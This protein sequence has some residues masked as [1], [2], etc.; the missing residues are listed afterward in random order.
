M[1]M[2]FLM[3]I[4]AKLLLKQNGGSSRE[5]AGGALELGMCEYTHS[6]TKYRAI[7]RACNRETH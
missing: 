5:G 7:Y 4:I 1:E 2:M 3:E 6:K